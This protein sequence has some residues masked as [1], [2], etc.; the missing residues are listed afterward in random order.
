MCN[1]NK[2]L[3]LILLFVAVG[4]SQTVENLE[5]RIENKRIIITFDLTDDNPSDPGSYDIT[6]TAKHSDGTTTKPMAVAGDYK[7]VKAGPGLKILWEPILDVLSVEGWTVSLSAVES[8]ASIDRKFNTHRNDGDDYFEKKQWRLAIK[9]YRAA[10][11]I[12]SRDSDVLDQINNAEI[13]IEYDKFMNQGDDYFENKEWNQAVSSYRRALEFKPNDTYSKNKIQSAE[14]EEFRK[15]GDKFFE[16]E[17]WVE[18]KAFYD[19]ALKVKVGDKDAISK[20]D[21]IEIILIKES[22][23]YKRKANKYFFNDEYD[24]ALTEYQKVIGLN[25][26]NTFIMDKIDEIEKIK[27]G[28]SYEKFMSDA[29]KYH[30]KAKWDRAVDSYISAL[31][32]IP[33]D[34][35]ALRG[36][37]ETKKA[38]QDEISNYWYSIVAFSLHD[39][40]WLYSPNY[41][42]SM[43]RVPVLLKFSVIPTKNKNVSF[44]YGGSVLG[45]LT[46][47]EYYSVFDLV[48]FNI[49][50]LSIFEN[51]N[52]RVFLELDFGLIRFSARSRIFNDR[53]VELGLISSSSFL[54]KLDGGLDISFTFEKRIG[55]NKFLSFSVGFFPLNGFGEKWY[56]KSDIDEWE[57]SNSE[58]ENQPIQLPEPEPILDCSYPTYDNNM[59]YLGFGIHF[60]NIFGENVK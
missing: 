44:F 16:K 6:L 49:G 20:I 36:I 18:A 34:K 39:I 33:D 4:F 14:Y 27:K 48:S 19:M 11:R 10:L 8:E 1:T 54:A 45:N 46:F 59:I 3:F 2:F 57:T 24:K 58:S 38:K 9:H 37:D 29:Y 40:K 28:L 43:I 52:S 12:K 53:P 31:D 50:V 7:D 30:H 56:Y 22:E 60:N 41:Q 21:E 51:I 25:G 15:K 55:Y 13:E 23:R 26:G 17:Q 35:K 32:I 47:S 5:Q 42:T